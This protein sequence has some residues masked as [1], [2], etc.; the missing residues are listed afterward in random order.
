MLLT[1]YDWR[2]EF[3]FPFWLIWYERV[4][5]CGLHEMTAFG[6]WDEFVDLD[7]L[8]V[9]D[10]IWVWHLALE[11]DGHGGDCEAVLSVFWSVE[12]SDIW[13]ATW[14]HQHLNLGIPDRRHLE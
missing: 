4:Q 1:L 8:R 2:Y 11:G 14:S 5:R 10:G 9:G 12:R 7:Q 6:M 3:L 13:A